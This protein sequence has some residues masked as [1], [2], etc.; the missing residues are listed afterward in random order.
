MAAC[1]VTGRAALPPPLDRCR[2]SRRQTI[3][4]DAPG[5]S[6]RRISLPALVDG[7]R[8]SRDPRELA[9]HLWVD[10]PRLRTRMDTLDPVEVAELEHHLDGDWLWIP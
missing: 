3:C 4:D 5:R 9:E 2:T 10:E 8:W 7:L 6:L 1:A